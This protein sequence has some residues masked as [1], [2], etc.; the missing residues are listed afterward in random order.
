MLIPTPN[1]D[2][3]YRTEKYQLPKSNTAQ[4]YPWGPTLAFVPSSSPLLYRV[5]AIIVISQ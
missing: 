5:G 2:S 1:I 3:N 4:H